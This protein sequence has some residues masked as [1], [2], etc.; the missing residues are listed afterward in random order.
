MPRRYL[1]LHPKA[2]IRPVCSTFIKTLLPIERSALETFSL[3]SIF[4]KYDAYS[5]VVY[6]IFYLLHTEIDIGN[7]IKF[8]L[9]YNSLI[10]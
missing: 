10:H 3:L 6:K 9:Y 5:D 7:F 2:Q 1:P 8:S 4:N